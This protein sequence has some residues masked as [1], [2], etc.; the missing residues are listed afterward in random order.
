M[1]TGD[2][3]QNLDR[4]AAPPEGYDIA[5]VTGGTASCY[6]IR[7][8]SV[9]HG[10]L[11]FNSARGIGLDD[12]EWIPIPHH[13][14]AW[15]LA[16]WTVGN[17]GDYNLDENTLESDVIEVDFAN[18]TLT[19]PW[20]VRRGDDIMSYFKH[21][22]GIGWEY[23]LSPVVEDSLSHA[24]HTGDQLVIYVCGNDLDKA[25]FD[26]VVKDPAP[27]ANIVVPVSNKDPEGNWRTE[28]EG[29]YW[30][31][32]RVTKHESGSDTIWGAR[33]G[34]PY[35]TR[36]DS[37]LKRLEKPANA[38]WE[39]VYSD[40]VE[41][42]DLVNGDKLR[43]TAQDG[44]VKDYYISVLDYR[45][46]SDANLS[47][48]TWPD[49]PEYY[50]GIYGWIGDTIPGFGSQIFNYNVQVPL[51]AEGIPALVA[52][53]SDENAKVVVSRASS[54]SGSTE[55]RTIK[56]KVTAED[57]TTINNYSVLLNKE[58]DLDNQQPY[59]ADP[60]I[61]EVSQN[62]W[63]SGTDFAEICNPGNQPLDLSN[64]MLAGGASVNPAEI[65]STTNETNWLNRYNKY[66]PGYKWQKE[67]EWAV[68]PYIA[69]KD[70]SVNALVQPGDVFTMGYVNRSECDWAAYPAKTQLDVQFNNAVTDCDDWVNQWG[71]EIGST[72]FN[73]WHTNLIYL[74]KIL[75]DSV[76][77]GLKPA[78]DPN[79][80]KLID[81]L[82]KD[83][84]SLWT[85][86]DQAI[87][88]PF[89]LRRK[90]EIHKGNP[91]VG[92]ALG[93]TPE[94]AEYTAVNTDY[95]SNQG[96]G[97]PWVMRNIVSDL[98]THFFNQ[99]T[100]YMSTVGS[101]V[102]I[103]SK[104][105]SMDEQIKGVTTGTTVSDFFD[106]IIKADT[107]QTLTVTS[108][109]DGSELAMDALLSLNDTL[110][111]ISADSTNTSKYILEVT[112][113]GLSSDAVL[114]STEYDIQ[115]TQQPT[116]LAK[117]GTGTISGF[118]YGTLLKTVVDNVTLPAGASLTVINAKGAYEPFK[119]LNYDTIYV[120]ATVNLEI[121]F[122]V[123]A[124][125]GETTITYQLVPVS[126]GDGPF[127]T[128]N[129][130]TVNQETKLIDNVPEG[131]NTQSFLSK[132]VLS[133]GATMKLV[134]KMGF[135]RTDGVVADDDNI[136]VTSADGEITVVYYIS[137]LKASSAG[138]TL[139]YI[140]SDTY[141]IDQVNKTIDGVSS[142]ITIGDFFS[143]ITAATGASVIIID[144]DGNEK[145]SGIIAV[146]DLV[147]VTSAD[148]R[149]EAMYSFG[150]LTGV[151]NVTST[152]IKFYPNPS[153]G[154]LNVS[155]V[156][157]GQRIQIYNSV[158][159]RVLD[160]NVENNHEII[161]IKEYP[162]GVYLII[163]SNKDQLIG[164]Y[165][166]LKY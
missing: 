48:I 120:D 114:T 41:K 139:A 3:G 56:F 122:Q 22:P 67:A 46:N 101:N 57:D 144:R 80:F 93:T 89:S 100:E 24:A 99:P 58:K 141:N 145:T 132:L 73:Q 32:P 72:A 135:E 112:E 143:N 131:I 106:N 14:G 142:N 133:E 94:D 146:D 23:E 18:K 74:F 16:P 88:N 69:E 90:P 95:F 124:E 116:D 36:V 140:L 165:K 87:G 128:S 71:E 60:F 64:Y 123:V 29:G 26:I 151:N 84:G 138:I 113:N 161:S 111:V 61:S 97:W 109:A 4:T 63:W 77:K 33:G 49:I 163:V 75:N 10:N 30:G 59:S 154:R 5:G 129:I 136:L 107:G 137:K 43:V 66:I 130:F 158:G 85:L 125:D 39:I 6:L 148:G 70:L 9:K 15:R 92:E 62:F 8:F 47:S 150:E 166:A 65:I 98:G 110:T 31:W 103:V 51:L 50:K 164:K 17:Q 96:F 102:Y 134:D 52:K 53:P 152:Q 42:P 34:I 37:L 105:Y 38:D 11:D 119:I 25:T 126:S 91:N 108:T 156:E 147:K 7:K 19:V 127:V 55:D 149:L 121:Y 104:G 117:L 2:N 45:A 157:K 20:G 40:G 27:N 162:A 118:P 54:L 160:M 81:V 86:G 79:D 28:I 83:D 155:G 12:S 78:T 1:F 68:Q 153:D 159:Y 115:I 44:T 13:D 35:A 21:K 82:G 76:K